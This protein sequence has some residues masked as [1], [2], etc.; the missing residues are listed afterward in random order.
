MI[1][2]AKMDRFLEAWD[3]FHWEFSLALEDLSDDNLW[4]RAR[5]ELLSIGEL[6]GHV[7]YGEVTWLVAGAYEPDFTALPIKSPFLDRRFGYFP[8]TIQMP[9][10]IEMNVEEV[11]SEMNRVHREVK[12]MILEIDP[13]FDDLMPGKT[14]LSEGFSRWGQ[15]LQYQMFHVAYHAG[16]AFSVRH[17]LGDTPVDN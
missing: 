14:E 12:H 8:N 13:D 15:T 16:Q 6:C 9:V 4:R 17:L 2:M 1:G 10:Q 3:E 7:V 5:P 11:L